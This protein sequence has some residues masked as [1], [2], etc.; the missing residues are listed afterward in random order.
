[1]NEMNDLQRERAEQMRRELAQKA[2]KPN[3]DRFVK[4]WL[5]PDKKDD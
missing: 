1:M 5:E 3:Y 2:Q 4:T